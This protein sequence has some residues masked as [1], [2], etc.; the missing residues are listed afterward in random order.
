MKIKKLMTRDVATCRTSDSTHHA[1]HLMWEKDC[2]VL[3]VVDEQQRLIGMMTDRDVCMAGYTTGRKLDQILVGDVMSRNVQACSPDDSIADA[4]TAMKKR[5]VRRLPVVDSQSRVVGI[6]SLN[7]LA[8]GAVEHA[9]KLDD[10]LSREHVA[11]T[12]ASVCEPWCSILAQPARPA[13]A[14][15]AA[16][17]PAPLSSPAR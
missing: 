7:D 4:E 14:A 16:L 6:L 11:E 17:A 13:S 2:G 1:A 3:P 9:D 8:R 5:H 15:T 12:L 10:G